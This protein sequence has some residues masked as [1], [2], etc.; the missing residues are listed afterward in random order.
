[1]LERLCGE[2]GIAISSISEVR[3]GVG[4]GS[5]TGLR[6]G[7]SFAKGLAWSL[8]VPLVGCSSCAGV[9]A[10]AIERDKAVGRVGVVADARRDEV[11]A[12]VYIKGSPVGEQLSPQ[13]VP[14]HELSNAPWSGDGTVWVSPQRDFAVPGITLTA[15]PDGAK[16]I[17]SLPLEAPKGFSLEEIAVLEPT[18]LRAVAAKTIEER[19]LGT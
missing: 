19:R 11:F 2:A 9:A 7:M 3:I 8:R 1:M 18:Y 16:G 10:A 14:F 13:I 5:F 15:E 6:I 4:P 17:L 12:A